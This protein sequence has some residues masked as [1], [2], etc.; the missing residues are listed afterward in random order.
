MQKYLFKALTRPLLE[1]P[2]VLNRKLTNK[3][4]GKI[5]V[6]QNS[7]LRFI[8]GIKKRERVS[9]A[10]LHEELDI[11]PLNIRLDKLA[12][13]VY[14]IMK[15][16]YHVS[17]NSHTEA[18][19]RFPDYEIEGNPLRTKRKSLAEHIEKY[20]LKPRRHKNAIREEIL[21]ENWKAPPS[22]YTHT[23]KPTPLPPD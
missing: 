7:A 10:S 2:S 20:I 23:G 16:K 8:K 1:Y 18:N 5:P 19:Y 3:N 12:C 17:K 9:A 11:D 13:K 14:N 6:I 22:I 15:T 4:K 21:W